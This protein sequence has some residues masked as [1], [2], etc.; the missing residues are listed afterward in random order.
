VVSA[1]VPTLAYGPLFV[2]CTVSR[3]ALMPA[4]GPR[5]RP[6]MR[7][8]AWRN[9]SSQLRISGFILQSVANSAQVALYLL[10]EIVNSISQRD[11]APILVGSSQLI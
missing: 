9:T 10:N 3:T 6:L 4:D 11:Q 1:H 8:W 5:L 7:V 2:Y